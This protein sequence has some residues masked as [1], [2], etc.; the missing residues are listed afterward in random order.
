[1]AKLVPFKGLRY[2]TETIG[3][4]S[5]V[6][7]P[8]YDV[9]SPSAQGRYYSM[10]EYNIIRIELGKEF[11]D[12]NEN[13]N[14]YTRA[15]NYLR[16]WMDKHILKHEDKDAFY[17]YDQE[18]TLKNGDKKVRRGFV[19]LVELVE[20]SKGIVLPHEETLS[21]AKQDRFNLMNTT[22]GNISQIFSL[23]NDSDC[24]DSDCNGPDS[25]DPDCMVVP[26]LNSYAAANKPDIEFTDDDGI[27]E[28]L[29]A[30]KDAG[31]IS[32]IQAV[33]AV[34]Q[35]FIADGHHRYETALN[36]RNRLI[37]ENPGHTGSEPFNYVMM[38]LVEMDDPGLV[39][40]PTH[41]VLKNL[42]NFNSEDFLQAVSASF[43]VEKISKGCCCECALDE[44]LESK[45]EEKGRNRV[46][47]AY[48][49][50]AKSS[51]YL[52]TLNDM[53][54]MEK[55]LPHKHNSYRQLDVS[56]LH[57]LVLEKFFGIDSENMANQKNLTYTRDAAE[58]INWV[59]SGTCQCA[60]FLN[61]TK[62]SQIKDVSLAKEKMPQKST[63]FY[64]KLL[65]G[66]VINKF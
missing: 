18:F 27:V 41:R 37:A 28:R 53:S 39:V 13:N 52:L 64:P 8:P 56:I 65:T 36:F 47:F 11:P 12:D 55:A 4:L 58:A 22:C 57:T 17:I 66:L 60:F 15:G 25:N 23:Y 26:V 61:A 16:S 5:Q 42:E 40:F 49:D 30:V 51:Y 45:L 34:R 29:W 31:I 59:S 33:M 48:Y 35:L 7:T 38:M 43:E 54:L 1:M 32:K 6:T 50:G 2:N 44:H 63:Y 24:N 21:K 20:F 14:K 10:S 3:E 19:C 62:V 46:A 9:I